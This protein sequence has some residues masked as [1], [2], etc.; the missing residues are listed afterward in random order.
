MCC[1][2]LT[3]EAPSLTRLLAISLPQ[4]H[5]SLGEWVRDSFESLINRN[6]SLRNIDRFHYLKLAVRGKPA[7]ALKTLPVSD[8]NYD[9]AWELLCKRYEDTNELIDHHVN[10]FSINR[11][12]NN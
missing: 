8:S 10:A 9:T 12:R 6:E 11:Y 4:F 7:R 1:I 5:G 3:A 2:R